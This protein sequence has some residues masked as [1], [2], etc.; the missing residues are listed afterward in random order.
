MKWSK[1][2][3]KEEGFYLRNTMH[4]TLRIQEVIRRYQNGR[5]FLVTTSAAG[6]E[7]E[8]SPCP[9]MYWGTKNY[10]WIKIPSIQNSVE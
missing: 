6:Y 10:C 7:L 3:P 9:H 2:L 5:S 8:I 1:V 4:N